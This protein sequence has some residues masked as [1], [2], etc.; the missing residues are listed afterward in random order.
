MHST[1][2]VIDEIITRL[3]DGFADQGGRRKVHDGVRPDVDERVSDPIGV[4]KIDVSD[5]YLVRHGAAMTTPKAVYDHRLVAQL[6]QPRDG[7]ATDVAGSASYNNSHYIPV[8][9]E[10][11]RLA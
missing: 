6:R 7:D 2:E 3:L 5:R 1:F 11:A 4:P 9:V 10:A 8:L